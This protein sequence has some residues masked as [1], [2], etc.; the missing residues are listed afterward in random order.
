MDT[1][2][3]ICRIMDFLAANGHS[4]STIKTYRQKLA[5]VERD[6]QLFSGDIPID[7]RFQILDKMY[8]K[9]PEERKILRQKPDGIKAY[10]YR[11]RIF[12]LFLEETDLVWNKALHLAVPKSFAK[13]VS[14]VTTLS[15]ADVG[16]LTADDWLIPR[17]R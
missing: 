17:N 2:D 8:A 15:D 10:A 13:Q 4:D 12:L 16:K 7:E 11:L 3:A 1:K 9:E 6:I 5:R 14:I